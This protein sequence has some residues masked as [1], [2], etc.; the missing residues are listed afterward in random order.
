MT[1]VLAKPIALKK[2]LYGL[3]A[4][5]VMTMGVTAVT[6]P[7]EVY[8]ASSKKK[9][10]EDTGISGSKVTVDS[11]GKVTYSG[12]LAT[13][14]DGSAWTKLIA[15]YRFFIAGVSGVGAVSMILFFIINFMKLGAT[16]A[17]PSERSRVIVGLVFSGLA[18]AGLGAVTFIVGIFFNALG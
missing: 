13:G 10:K 2:T 7:V 6:N 15:K 17:N 18:A 11:S 3:L 14:S 12:D 16:S 4:A 5:F 1:M 9:E 8:A